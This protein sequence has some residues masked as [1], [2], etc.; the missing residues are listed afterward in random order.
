MGSSRYVQREV[1][2]MKKKSAKVG[3]GW[4]ISGREKFL[5]FYWCKFEENKSV[6]VEG[7][8]GGFTALFRKKK[9]VATLPW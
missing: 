1:L 7:G 5:D 3:R 8:G 4:K 6:P 9:C 2:G